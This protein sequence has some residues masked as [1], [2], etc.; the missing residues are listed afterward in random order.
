MTAARCWACM[1]SRPSMW[2]S[3]SSTRRSPSA[4]WPRGPRLRAGCSADDVQ[5]A[6]DRPADP[7][8][9]V[10]LDGRA[11]AGGFAAAQPAA[12]R[13]CGRQPGRSGARRAGAAWRLL[14][15]RADRRQHGGH[16]GRHRRR[17]RVHAAFRGVAAG[18]AV[19][20]AG[21]DA[22]LRGVVC[23][24]HRDVHRAGRSGA[25][26]AVD[27]RA[28]ARGDDAG[29]P[30]AVAVPRAAAA[31]LGLQRHHRGPDPRARAAGQAR[32]DHQLPRHPGAHRGRLP[33]RRRGWRGAAGHRECVRAGH[34]HR[35]D[36]DDDARAHRLFRAGRGRG[37]DPHAHRRVTAFDLSGLQGRDR[38]GGRLCRRHRPVPARAAR[39]ADLAGSGR[40]GQEGA[41]RARPADA[42]R[43]ADAVPRGPR[44]LRRDR[45]RVQPGGGRRDAERCDEHRHGRPGGAA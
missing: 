41:D 37:A 6:A 31:G 24:D 22:R 36:R 26:A 35:R 14:H 9:C 13:R 7:R 18:G 39:R 1:P 27:E 28:R 4:T 16:P 17:G 11:V 44:G 20:R 29:R 5:P 3:R 21:C 33:G 25:Q 23:D 10:L 2:S 32:R 45:Q 19:A 8:Q 40:T 38:R 43:D 42:V 34:P 30:D 12:A 15:R